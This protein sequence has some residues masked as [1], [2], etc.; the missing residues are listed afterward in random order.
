MSEE[1]KEPRIVRTWHMLYIE[2]QADPFDNR[3]DKEFCEEF[4][5][6][7]QNF[8][9]WKTTYRSYIF[10]EVESI[11]K[12]YLNEYRSKG[13]KALAKKLDKDTNAI[14]LLFQLLGD[15][16][17]KTESRVEMSP[18]DQLRRI[19]AL[20]STIGKRQTAWDTVDAKSRPEGTEE[21]PIPSESQGPEGPSTP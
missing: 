13:H 1:V 16:V 8:R 14:K 2:S 20:R 18:D 19:A 11:R 21:A 9:N 7:Y 4:G 12:N 10:K 3:S 17:E 6:E 5:I 15:L